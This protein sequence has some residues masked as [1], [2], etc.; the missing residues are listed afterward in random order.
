MSGAGLDLSV[1][2]LTKNE[3]ALLGR[4]IAS[5]PF[6]AEVV[7]VDSGS[8]DRTCELAAGLGARVVHEPW[9]GHFGDQRNRGDGHATC[10]WV[11]QLDADET[12]SP[13]LAAELT[14]FLAAPPAGVAA[15]RMPRKELIFGRWIEHGGWYPQYKLRLYRAGAGCW[16][17]RVHEGYHGYPGVP[18][19]FGHPILHDSYKDIQ[20]FID[21]FNRYSSLDAEAAFAEGKRFSLWKLLFQPLERFFGRYIVHR[22]YKDGTHGFVIALLVGLNYF[23]RYLK[24]WEKGCRA[25]TVVIPPSGKSSVG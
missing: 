4:C 22:G 18:H 5:V 15:A 3:E 10:G 7:V 13:E 20:T 11:L 19:T 9:T 2:I 6:A 25:A 16:E 21:K 12:V 23:M 24:L 1:V 14:A 17:G 8:T